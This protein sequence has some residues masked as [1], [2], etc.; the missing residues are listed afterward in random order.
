MAYIINV[1]SVEEFTNLLESQ[2]LTISQ[3]I[4]N[5][6]LENLNTRKRFLNVLEIYVTEQDQII[7]LTV[8]RV[9]FISTLERNL[10]TLEIH[11]EYELCSKVR[12]AIVYLKNKVKN[13]KKS[14]KSELK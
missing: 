7:D 8:D 11:E 12:D 4:V 5:V 3:E 10:T 13:G 6:I 1:D 2:D 14:S 9:N